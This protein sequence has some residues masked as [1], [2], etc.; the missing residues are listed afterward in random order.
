VQSPLGRAL[1]GKEVGDICEVTTPRGK[2]DLEIV[3][4]VGESTT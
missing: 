4:L 3:E 2:D 1:L